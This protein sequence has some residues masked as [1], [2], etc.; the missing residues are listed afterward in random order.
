MFA[1]GI[2]LMSIYSD[3][4][5][6][7]RKCR[8]IWNKITELI[9]IDDPTDFVETTLDDNEDEFIMLEVEKNTSAVRDKYRN[10]LVFVLYSVFNDYFQASLVQY[11]Y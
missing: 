5:D 10:D 11:R 4:N 6:F 3:D 2:T 8:E 1:S 9:G 7:F